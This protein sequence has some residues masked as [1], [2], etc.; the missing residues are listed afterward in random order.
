MLDTA[1]RKE[2]MLEKNIAEA[3]KNNVSMGALLKKVRK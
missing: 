1:L 2:D 3:M